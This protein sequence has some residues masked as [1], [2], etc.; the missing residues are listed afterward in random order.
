MASA[1][2]HGPTDEGVKG[3]PRQS[4]ML[5]DVSAPLDGPGDPRRCPCR[6]GPALGLAA[7]QGLV[8]FDMPK[9][10]ERVVAH[11]L[12]DPVTEIPSGL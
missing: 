9:S 2:S 6:R 7:H 1:S 5:A 12:P 8:N 11:R 3:L 4:G 10:D